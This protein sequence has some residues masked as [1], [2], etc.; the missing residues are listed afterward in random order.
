MILKVKGDDGT[1]VEEDEFAVPSTCECVYVMKKRKRE[2]E[3][4]KKL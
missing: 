1:T 2:N 3:R 4:S